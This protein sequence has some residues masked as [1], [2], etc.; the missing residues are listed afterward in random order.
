[1]N[2]LQERFD[3]LFS[4][5]TEISSTLQLDEVLSRV[6]V[7]ARRL[8]EARVASLLL[9]DTERSTLRPAATCGASDAYLALPDRAL[10]SSLI[11]QVIAT[12]R[13][14]HIPD[15]RKET[16]Y[17]VSDRRARRA[18]VR[19]SRSRCEPRQRSLACSTCIPEGR[20]VL[21]TTTCGC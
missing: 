1:M 12:G 9:I 4:V 10:T 6:T 14:L 13:P 2:A 3:A 19:Y 11:S 7:H 8:M 20:A 5:G 21:M 15:M 17:R 18:C 16:R